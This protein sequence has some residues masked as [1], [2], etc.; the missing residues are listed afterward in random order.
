MEKLLDLKITLPTSWTANNKRKSLLVTAFITDSSACQALHR[1]TRA[2]IRC[3]CAPPG[4]APYVPICDGGWLPARTVARQLL[5]S[6]LKVRGM[7]PW[8]Q[9]A[10]S[11]CCPGRQENPPPWHSGCGSCIHASHAWGGHSD[12][13]HF[14]Q[15][16]VIESRKYLILPFVRAEMLHVRHSPSELASLA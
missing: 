11:H 10:H 8:E 4:P 16:G 7:A 2:A 9:T 1:G 14:F 5:Q 13:T 6:L 3:A 15:P 12:I